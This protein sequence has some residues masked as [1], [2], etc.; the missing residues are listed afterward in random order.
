MIVDLET[1][2]EY[3]T[4]SLERPAHGG[5]CARHE[6]GCSLIDRW[7]F[8]KGPINQVWI[9]VDQ[10]RLSGIDRLTILAGEKAGLISNDVP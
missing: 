8:L 5:T 3:G 9:H 7:A 10:Q 6:D 2:P 4:G 1:H